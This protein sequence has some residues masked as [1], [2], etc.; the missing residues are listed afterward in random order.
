MKLLHRPTQE[1]MNQLVGKCIVDYIK[2]HRECWAVERAKLVVSNGVTYK[3]TYW[4]WE[5]E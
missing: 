1:E 2:G 3:I 5:R 4:A